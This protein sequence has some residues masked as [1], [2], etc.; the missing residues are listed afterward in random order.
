MEPFHVANYRNKTLLTQKFSVTLTCDLVLHMNDVINPLGDT[1]GETGR[2]H[3][4]LYVNLLL[5][6][7][8]LR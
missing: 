6:T 8:A 3:P 7:S 2:L 5:H 1:S 4:A